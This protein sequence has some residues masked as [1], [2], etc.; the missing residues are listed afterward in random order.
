MQLKLRADLAMGLVACLALGGCSTQLKKAESQLV[1]L[2]D[3]LP[4]HYNNAAQAEQDAKAGREPHPALTLDIARV[5]LPLLSDYVFYAQETAADDARRIVSQRLLTFQATKDGTIVETLHTFVQP[6][7][8]R[9]G[10]LNSGLFT[11]MMFKDTKPMGGCDVL[12]KKEGDKF[13]GA[14]VRDTCRVTSGSLGSVRMEMKIELSADELA[15]AELSYGP[16]NK[17]V[18]G[19]VT[20][21]FYRYQRG[22]GPQG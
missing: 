12:W 2:S 20:E 19:N 18:Q 8:W 11:S 16:G 15:T 1:E 6:A 21:P 9:D 17:L 10:H 13:T 7:R 5:A 4:G 14:N 3:L 22:D